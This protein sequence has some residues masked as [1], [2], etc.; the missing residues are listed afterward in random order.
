MSRVFTIA[1]ARAVLPD[2]LERAATVIG[3]R[4]DL[5]AAQSAVRRG[6]EPTGGI[7]HAKALEAHLQEAIDWFAARGIQ[8]KGIAPLIIDFPGELDGEP[9]L[10]CWLEGERELGWYHPADVGFMGRR[11]LPED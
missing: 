5:A 11:P 9:V 2:V 7:A 3:L 4:A 10:W 1:D 8:V 6:H